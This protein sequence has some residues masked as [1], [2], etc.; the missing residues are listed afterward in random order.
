MENRAIDE[1]MI[2][3][4]K[5]ERLNVRVLDDSRKSNLDPIDGHRSVIS[6]WIEK[7]NKYSDLEA[8]TFTTSD[9]IEGVSD[10]SAKVKRFLKNKVYYR[11]PLFIR[12]FLFFFYRYFLL[13]GFLDGRRGLI[14][15]VLH[16]FWYRFLVDVKIYERNRDST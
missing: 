9:S 1:H 15:H 4:G 12:P 8:K 5:L 11:I 13:L 7:H 3:S 16:S 2:V 14:I 10:L 6:F